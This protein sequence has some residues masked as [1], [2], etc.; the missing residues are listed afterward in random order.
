MPSTV[1]CR[2]ARPVF[3]LDRGRF[4]KVQVDVNDGGSEGS[5]LTPVELNDRSDAEE[6]GCDGQATFDSTQSGW[7]WVSFPFPST[8]IFL[9]AG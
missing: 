7:N 8:D 2:R 9:E 4:I 5:N 3:A 1:N 6:V